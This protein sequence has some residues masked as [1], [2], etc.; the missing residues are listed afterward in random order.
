[1]KVKNLY[2][3]NSETEKNQE[4]S[5]YLFKF[6]NVFFFSSTLLYISFSFTCSFNLTCSLLRNNINVSNATSC[7][8]RTEGVSR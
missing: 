7:I 8:I 5:S 1:M 2:P 4:R 3:Q 6:L